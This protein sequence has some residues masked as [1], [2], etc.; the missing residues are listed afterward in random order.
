MKAIKTFFTGI[1]SALS[2]WLGILAI[3]VSLLVLANI[4]DYCTGLAA[5]PY[6]NQKVSSYK[7]LRGIVKKVSMWLIVAVGA[8]LDM[9]LA[10][11]ADQ[12]GITVPFG[13]AIAS[14]VAIWLICNEI[15]SILENVADIGV[16]LPPF[17]V[18]IV[19]YIKTQTDD[20]ASAALPELPTESAD[21]TE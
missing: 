19:N 14:I 6:R 15:I 1:F 13:F 7:G 2:A 9:L 20:K 8:I 5:A 12:A 21:K 4:N 17:L 3:P 11:A 10:Y 16:S 18:K